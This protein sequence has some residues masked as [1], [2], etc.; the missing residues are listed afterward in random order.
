MARRRN[1]GANGLSEG[2]DANLFLGVPSPV[3]FLIRANFVFLSLLSA[4]FRAREKEK[5]KKEVDGWLGQL[6][7]TGSGF[8]PIY[9]G[10]WAP[11]GPDCVELGPRFLSVWSEVQFCLCSPPGLLLGTPLG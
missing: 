1:N 11:T 6:L 9:K 7:N 5:R 10:T 2:K 4:R 3:P 8:W